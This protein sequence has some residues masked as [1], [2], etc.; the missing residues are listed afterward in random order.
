MYEINAFYT[1][2][3]G[4]MLL[5]CMSGHWSTCAIMN[6]D[7]W[8]PSKPNLISFLRIAGPFVSYTNSMTSPR[9][10]LPPIWNSIPTCTSIQPVLA[11]VNRTLLAPPHYPLADWS[12]YFYSWW[13]PQSW[14]KASVPSTESLC[15]VLDC[16]H[17]SRRCHSFSLFLTYFLSFDWQRPL[18]VLKGLII[19][20]VLFYK[21]LSSWVI[22]F[23]LLF[24]N[25]LTVVKSPSKCWN[26]TFCR[27]A[28]LLNGP[29][30]VKQAIQ[31]ETRKKSLQ[32]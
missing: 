22:H 9:L 3:T 12:I 8:Y 32:K 19:F 30:S 13:K 27:Y 15:S 14:L 16:R 10:C 11:S 5:K 24:L 21:C 17:E 23:Y 7:Q 6:S 20:C 25:Y 18:W 31:L 4:Q 28:G 2:E 26:K 1:G 29:S